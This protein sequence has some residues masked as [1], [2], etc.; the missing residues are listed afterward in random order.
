MS[1]VAE[2]DADATGS[3][4]EQS[5]QV[6]ILEVCIDLLKN[7]PDS[8]NRKESIGCNTEFV[9]RKVA[10]AVGDINNLAGGLRL[11]TFDCYASIQHNVDQ[12]L[13]G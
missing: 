7:E 2:A 4:T 11:D 3:A 6:R 5:Q 9:S 1:E 10:D 13:V 8:L 12:P